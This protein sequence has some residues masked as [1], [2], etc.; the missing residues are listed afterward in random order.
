MKPTPVGWPRISSALFYEDA[1]D[2]TAATRRRTARATTGGSCSA[3]AI[4]SLVPDLTGAFAAPADRGE[5]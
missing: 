2:P 1:A 4:R 3:S 5:P